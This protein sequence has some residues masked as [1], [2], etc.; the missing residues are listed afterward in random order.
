MIS[1]QTRQDVLDICLLRSRACRYIIFGLFSCSAVKCLFSSDSITVNVLS[2]FVSSFFTYVC[3]L[4]FF[5]YV[6]F[7]SFSHAKSYAKVVFFCESCKKSLFQMRTSTLGQV[8]YP[9]YHPRSVCAGVIV[10]CQKSL[11]SF[12]FSSVMQLG[13]C[14]L[15]CGKTS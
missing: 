2:M 8:T 7:F 4:L 15:R 10:N 12:F 13:F 11:F 14:L 6:S 9:K 5:T 1:A 3:S